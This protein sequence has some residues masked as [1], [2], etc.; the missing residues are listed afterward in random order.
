MYLYSIENKPKP[1]ICS[2]FCGIIDPF[3]NV[4]VFFYTPYSIAIIMFI[5]QCLLTWH[6]SFCKSSVMNSVC[7]LSLKRNWEINKKRNTYLKRE[8]LRTFHMN[9]FKFCAHTF[10]YQTV[11]IHT[12]E[13]LGQKE[14]RWE[15]NDIRNKCWV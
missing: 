15:E 13:R 4:Y 9:I 12:K 8:V 14:E 5:V 7:N 2:H 6:N 1:Q 10:A 3:T 11:S